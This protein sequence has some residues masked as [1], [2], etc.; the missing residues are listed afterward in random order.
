MVIDEDCMAQEENKN[1]VK[2]LILRPN[3]HLY[4]KWDSKASL[5]F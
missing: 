1:A 5:I 3:G 4:S 2:Y